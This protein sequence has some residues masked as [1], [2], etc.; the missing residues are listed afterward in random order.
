[1]NYLLLMSVFTQCMIGEVRDLS[2]VE[3]VKQEGKVKKE[4]YLP[5]SKKQISRVVELWEDKSQD[6]DI[7]LLALAWMESRLRTYTKRGDKGK[8][9]GVYQIHAHHTFPMFRRKGGYRNWKV[10]E[11][12]REI[13]LE[14]AKLEGLSYSM[15]TMVRLL[16]ILDK[17][18][19]HPCHHNSGVYAKCNQWYK[20]RLDLVTESLR[21][22][23]RK[24]LKEKNMAMI[25]TGNPVSSAPT[26]KVQG[27]LD[28][29][30]GKDPV[31]E[32]EVYMSG[33][34]LAQQVKKGEV[35]APLW[36]LK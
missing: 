28:F 14:C 15:D 21:E 3:I 27:Y 10:S 26:E 7:R 32:D 18:E 19:R 22:S 16:R 17:K 31:K 25:R 13:A 35:E 8:A 2:G 24:C 20:Q 36:A 33:Y 5:A 9:C 29:M 1:M 12:K 6:L 11:N 34:N 23:K 30:A 4:A